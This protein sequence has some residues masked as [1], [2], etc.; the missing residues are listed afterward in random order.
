METLRL[1]AEMCQAINRQ[2][3]KIHYAYVK[4]KATPEN[5]VAFFN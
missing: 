3:N 2:G 4:H 1:A 5:E